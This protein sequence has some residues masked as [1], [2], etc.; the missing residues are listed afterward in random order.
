MLFILSLTCQAQFQWSLLCLICCRDYTVSFPN[1]V[2]SIDITYIPMPHGHMYLTAIIDWYSRRLVGHYLSDSL[3]AESVIH[4]VTETVKACG[5]PAI[6]N[7]DQGSQFTSDDYKNL[8]RNLNIRQSM[9][10]RSRWA[11]NI[12]I[13]RWFRSLKTEQLYPNEYRTPREL[14]RLINQYVDDYNNIRPH[15]AL[16]YKVP[17]EFTLL[18][19]LLRIILLTAT[20]K[21][22]TCLDKG[23][24]K[25]FQ[26]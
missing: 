18:A 5:V 24:Y 13:E 22:R 21:F 11:D 6:I 1:Q 12:M 9:D 26:H 16:G 23:H 3:E 4:A 19:S 25:Y 15:E 7:S 2:W 10:G 17:N 14:R 20:L 8:L